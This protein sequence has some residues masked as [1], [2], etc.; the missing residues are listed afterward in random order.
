M[1]LTSDPGV[2]AD[3]R[4][5]APVNRIPARIM[6]LETGPRAKIF[7]RFIAGEKLRLV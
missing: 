7:G 6:L 3:P 1:A 2:S 5:I 4:E